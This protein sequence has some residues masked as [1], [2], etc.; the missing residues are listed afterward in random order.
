MCTQLYSC[1]GT[2][3][4]NK[5]RALPEKMR[6]T[7]KGPAHGTLYRD[8]KLLGKKMFLTSHFLRQRPYTFTTT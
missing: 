6:K 5:L 8:E 7:I 1:T 3:G 2:L 4:Q